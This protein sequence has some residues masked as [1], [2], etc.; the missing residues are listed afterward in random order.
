VRGVIVDLDRSSP[1]APG[2]ADWA[3]LPPL[4]LWSFALVLG[5][6][7]FTLA[8]WTTRPPTTPAA[9]SASVEPDT[10]S[11]TATVPRGVLLR[12]LLLPTLSDVELAF[13]PDRLANEAA[14]WTLRS[15]VVIR[16]TRGVASVEGPAVIAWTEN[17]IAYWM[18]SHTRTTSDLI[19]VANQLK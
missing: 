7:V 3:A 10:I 12:P 6:V 18:T 14:S 17:G 2:P 8:V 9:Q 4:A 13:M 19:D 16:G 1:R 5:C 11:S 15:V